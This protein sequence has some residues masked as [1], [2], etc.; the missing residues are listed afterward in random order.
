MKLNE[1]FSI[2]LNLPR[3]KIAAELSAF[4]ARAAELACVPVSGFRVGAAALGA[5]G[6]VWLGANLEFAGLPLNFTV[7][8]EQA[9]VLNARSHG[10]TKL[11][12]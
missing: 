12:V 2:D 4:L 6:R 9:A 11:L 8:A 5:S 3:E 7:H 10:E 1:T